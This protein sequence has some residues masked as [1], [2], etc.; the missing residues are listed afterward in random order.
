[1]SS[2]W[3]K[4]TALAAS[5]TALSTAWLR[6]T[7]HPGCAKVTNYPLRLLRQRVGDVTLG[8]VLPRMKCEQCHRPPASV[9]LCD[10]PNTSGLGGT[11]QTWRVELVP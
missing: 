8:D 9:V 11:R 2:P 4:Q 3:T 1:M 6:L 10:D 5:L 7:C